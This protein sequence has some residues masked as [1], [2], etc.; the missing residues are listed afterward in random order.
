MVPFPVVADVLEVERNRPFEDMYTVTDHY[1][2]D[3]TAVVL[4]IERFA[5]TTN[6]LAYALLGDAVLRSWDAFPASSPGRGRVPV[7][8]IACVEAADPA[9]VAVG[10]RVSGYL[11]MAT[12]VA[13]HAAAVDGGLLTTDEPRAALLPVYRRLDVVE[14]DQDDATADVDTVLLPIYRSAAL[15]AEDLRHATGVIVSSASSRTA[16]ALSRLL[17]IRGVAV[18]GLTSPRNR[19]AVESLGVYTDVLT[20][21]RADHL[22]APDGAVYV[23]VAGS[24]DV[25]AAVHQRLGHRLRASIAVGATHARALPTDAPPGPAVSQFNTGDRELSAVA[26]RGEDAVRD[27]Y[28]AARAEL[29]SWASTWLR[30]TVVRGLS[31]A[32]QAWRDVVAGTSEPLSATVIR[33]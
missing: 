13:V 30:I 32:E 2:P 14:S 7:W 33:P 6:N 31:G 9:V 4:A 17:S 21:D 29:V 28:R 16:L 18:T 8:G 19:A 5:V 15:L 1:P 11:P 22:E 24:P 10:T 20:Y 12:R 25:T 26:E 23:D 27:D 3:P